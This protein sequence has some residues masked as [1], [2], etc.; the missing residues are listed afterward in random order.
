[1][2][3]IFILIVVVAIAVIGWLYIKNP[4]VLTQFFSQKPASVD[5]SSGFGA[6]LFDKVQQNPA[7]KLPEV[8]PFNKDVNP[9]EGAY[10]NPFN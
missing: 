3:K 10:N 2:K 4:A 6:Q 5:M 9:Y 7:E 1:M 8:N